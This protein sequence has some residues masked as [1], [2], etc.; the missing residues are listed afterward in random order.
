M[1]LF[2]SVG[3]LISSRLGFA[4]DIFTLF[5]LE[6][7]LA[8]LNLYSVL[9]SIISSLVL[10]LSI[11]I[12]VVILIGYLV[13]FLGG[14]IIVALFTV[15]LLNCLLLALILRLLAIRLKQMSFEKTRACLNNQP[16]KDNH[17]LPRRITKSHSG[18]G[19][20]N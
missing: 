1:N 9:I 18:N 11:W 2:N 3:G 7:K 19:R 4:K 13:L 12:T 16:I 20:K 15:L 5:R 8:G 14:N 10:L 6:A 17:E